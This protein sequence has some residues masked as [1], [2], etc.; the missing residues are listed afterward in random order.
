MQYEVK[1]YMYI[2]KVVILKYNLSPLF[3]H[4]LIPSFFPMLTSSCGMETFTSAAPAW[5]SMTLVLAT[6]RGVVMAAE[7]PPAMDP[8]T[9]LCHGSTGEPWRELQVVCV[10]GKDETTTK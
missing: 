5:A 6:S 4:P 3:S 8:H 2:D 9:A 10:R 7:V 1:L